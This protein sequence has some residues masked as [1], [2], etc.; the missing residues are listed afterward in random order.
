MSDI[1]TTTR[2]YA[3]NYFYCTIRTRMTV[4]VAKMHTT[5]INC[6][7]FTDA[8]CYWALENMISVLGIASVWILKMAT[9][10]TSAGT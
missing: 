2:K 6:P 1:V 5:E 9:W 3:L 10:A 7:Y 4:M 8:Y